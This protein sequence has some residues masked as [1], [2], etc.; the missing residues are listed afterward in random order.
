MLK[1]VL[2]SSDPGAGQGFAAQRLQLWM[3]S[4]LICIIAELADTSCEPIDP[5][6]DTSLLE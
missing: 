4:C 1:T 6:A 3:V 2:L 5:I